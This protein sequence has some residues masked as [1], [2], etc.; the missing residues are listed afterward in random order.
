MEA[1]CHTDIGLSPLETTRV[2]ITRAIG[3]LN[4]NAHP[5][6][7]KEITTSLDQIDEGWETKISY[8]HQPEDWVKPKFV[9]WDS[10]VVN[11]T[12][13]KE[14]RQFVE[15]AGFPLH[16][17]RYEGLLKV[18]HSRY[19]YIALVCRFNLLGVEI[20]PESIRAGLNYIDAPQTLK[21]Q[22]NDL[23]RVFYADLNTY[24]PERFTHEEALLATMFP[25]LEVIEARRK[26]MVWGLYNDIPRHCPRV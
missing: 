10:I 4:E 11:V 19:I 25:H 22:F 23:V 16:R 14:G 6:G 15:A 18:N 20:G 9:V 7:L 1:Y 17:V 2:V 12:N 3:W 24:H 8:C 21:S 5:Y 26:I 13:K